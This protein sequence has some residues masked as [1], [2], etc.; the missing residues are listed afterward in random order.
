MVPRVA[1]LRLV[2]RRTIPVSPCR[3]PPTW[4]RRGLQRLTESL[5]Y[6]LLE[7]FPIESEHQSRAERGS[8]ARVAEQ[9]AR[10]HDGFPNAAAQLEMERP[11]QRDAYHA[12]P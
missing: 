2:T 10:K 12:G 4:S 1:F 11:D 8:V 7:T 6:V 9:G 3:P 5:P